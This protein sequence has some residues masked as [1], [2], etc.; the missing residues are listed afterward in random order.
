MLAFVLSLLLVE[1]ALPWFNNVADKQMPIF[2]D[3]PRFWVVALG[4]TLLAGLI[5]GSYPAFYLSSFNPVKVLKGSFKAGRWAA[6]PRQILIVLQFT[7]S[8]SLIIGTIIVFQQ[9]IYVKDRPIGYDRTGLITLNIINDDMRQHYDAMRNELL[10]LFGLASFVAEQR[11]K[12]IGVQ[13]ILGASVFQLWGLL[14]KEFVLLVGIGFA[15]AAPLALDVM[16]NWLLQYQYR[17]TISVWVFVVTMGL[18]LLITLTTVSW[19]A[20][21]A[22]RANPVK[23]LRSE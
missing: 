18:A 12:E 16:R 5:A 13:K 22:A 15:I 6:L 20:V 19:Q 3:S 11:V 9:I 8:V 23:S 10:G 7:V 2:W 1:L 4:G 21:R 17:V 14:S